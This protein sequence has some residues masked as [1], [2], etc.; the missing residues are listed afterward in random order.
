[1]MSVLENFRQLSDNSFLTDFNELDHSTT[2]R[3]HLRSRSNKG[4]SLGR[5]KGDTIGGYDIWSFS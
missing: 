2:K 3:R 1:M 5:Q 4:Y